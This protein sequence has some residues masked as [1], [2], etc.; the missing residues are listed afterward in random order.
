MFGEP[1]MLRGFLENVRFDQPSDSD[2]EKGLSIGSL[3][4]GMADRVALRML[5]FAPDWLIR[6]GAVSG[7]LKAAARRQI[8]SASGLCVIM[9]Q[10]DSSRADVVTGRTTQR[11]WLA[12]V[13]ERLYAQPMMSLAVLQNALDNGTPALVASLGGSERVQGLFREFHALLPDVGEGPVVPS[14]GSVLQ[15]LPPCAQL[16]CH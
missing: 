3:E 5:R 6:L 10:A 15:R 4:V 9:F 7:K 16:G 8:V 2:V 13:R 1:S 14:C 11:A 12:L